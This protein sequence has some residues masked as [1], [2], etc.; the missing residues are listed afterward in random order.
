MEMKPV[1][2]VTSLHLPKP[3]IFGLDLPRS[4]AFNRGAA[5]AAAAGRDAITRAVVGSDLGGM[6]HVLLA[7]TGAMSLQKMLVLSLAT[8]AFE[9]TL[10]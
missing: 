7:W 1:S 9:V 4:T 2:H 3:L 8:D 6:M 5:A 10:Y